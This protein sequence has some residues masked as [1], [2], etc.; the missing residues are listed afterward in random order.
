MRLSTRGLLVLALIVVLAGV[1]TAAT[2]TATPKRQLETVRYATSFG[3][4]G[5]DGFVYVAIEKGYFR[6]VGLDVE[7]VPGLGTDNARLLASGQIDYAGSEITGTMVG[8]VLGSFLGQVR[9][10]DEPGDPGGNR[11]PRRRGDRKPEGGGGA[12]K[13]RPLRICRRPS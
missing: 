3:S 10:G 7:V 8:R 6:D 12:S 1:L 5:R 13:A 4:F 2:A 9:G 11:I